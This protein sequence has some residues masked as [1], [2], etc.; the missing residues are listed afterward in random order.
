MR[1]DLKELYDRKEFLKDKSRKE[2]VKKRHEK[3]LRTA[4]ENIEHLCDK[5]TFKELGSLLVAGQSK[6]L[7]QKELIKKTP[8]DG[9]VAG[10]GSINEN[11]FG[12]E[13]SPWWLTKYPK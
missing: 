10:L 12:K 13:K 2:S 3:G 7:T 11:F 8:A 9:L 1:K 6:R 4:R 5:E